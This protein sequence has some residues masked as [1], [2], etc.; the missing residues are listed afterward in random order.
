MRQERGFTLVEALVAIIVFAVGIMA[1]SNLML[2]A[3]SSS[4]A[5]NYS[6]AA[7]AAAIET[8]DILKS[9]TYEKL[10]V[11]EGGSITSDVGS[12]S[13]CVA[14]FDAAAGIYNCDHDV[15]GVGPVHVRWAIEGMLPGL[16]GQPTAVRITV[17][18][19]GSGPLTGPRTRAQFTTLRS[20]TNYQ[21][22]RFPA[23]CPVQ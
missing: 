18:A 9:T 20:C 11:G 23:T 22:D 10:V 5:A 15:N 1:V 16:D 21:A 6:S 12:R 4:K 2:V 8:L 7:T 19:E 14:D 3:A 13:P 17:A